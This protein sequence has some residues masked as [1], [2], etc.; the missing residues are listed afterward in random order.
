MFKKSFDVNKKK[1]DIEIKQLNK[2]KMKGR[3]SIPFLTELRGWFDNRKGMICM[4]ENHR[5]YS[6]WISERQGYF[7]RYSSE[8][9]KVAGQIIMPAYIEREKINHLLQMNKKELKRIRMQIADE[10]PVTI[11]QKREL[12]YKNKKLKDIEKEIMNNIGSM[13]ENKIAIEEAE[14]EIQ[15]LLQKNKIVAEMQV[16]RYLRGAKKISQW[17][18]NI[19]ENEEIRNL[20]DN[21]EIDF[22]YDSEMES[23]LI[24]EKESDKNEHI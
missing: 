14:H 3:Y 8:I 17:N 4:N 15:Q 1:V 10:V 18:E 11:E 9:Y 12:L 19:I 7:D 13:K 22:E 2:P 21:I 24:E 6:Q 23:I 20:F 16:K 5:F